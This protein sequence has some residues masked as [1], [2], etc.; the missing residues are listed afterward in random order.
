MPKNFYKYLGI[1]WITIVGVGIIYGFIR[2]LLGLE[3][4]DW[5]MLLVVICAL[6]IGA[7]IKLFSR[8]S[9]LEKRIDQI[10]RNV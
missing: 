5:L 6:F 10:E 1:V 2:F 7:I 3:I 4:Y 9:S 8:V